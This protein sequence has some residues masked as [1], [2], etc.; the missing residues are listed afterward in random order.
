MS[1]NDESGLIIII[2]F[3]FVIIFVFVVVVVVLFGWF[4][5]VRY[6][7]LFNDVQI[8]LPRVETDDR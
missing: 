8:V 2:I 4:Q 7:E 5:Q 1:F 3:F 6:E